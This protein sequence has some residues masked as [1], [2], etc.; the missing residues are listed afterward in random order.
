M[1]LNPF[2]FLPRLYRLT[3]VL[4][5]KAIHL[6]LGVVPIQSNEATDLL[7]L[8]PSLNKTCRFTKKIPQK[9]LPLFDFKLIRYT[10]LVPVEIE[11]KRSEIKE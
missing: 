10:L 7:W 8:D 4:L 3:H 1:S 9:F 5:T 2:L 6:F 11:I